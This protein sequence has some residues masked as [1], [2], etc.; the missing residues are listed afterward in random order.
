[1]STMFCQHATHLKWNIFSVRLFNLIKS[2]LVIIACKSNCTQQIH[3]YLAH[4]IDEWK[5]LNLRCCMVMQLCERHCIQSGA[6]ITVI[7]QECSWM[8]TEWGRERFKLWYNYTT[9]LLSSNIKMYVN[10]KWMRESSKCIF[11]LTI[12]L[13]TQPTTWCNA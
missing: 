6:Q 3:F 8:E 4:K 2:M 12:I 11:C 13:S 10:G 5:N 1:M 7:L 9:L